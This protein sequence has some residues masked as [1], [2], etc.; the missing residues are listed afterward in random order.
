MRVHV[1]HVP[2]CPSREGA[3]ASQAAGRACPV[4]RDPFWLR[5]PWPG[6]CSP[7]VPT[8][9]SSSRQAGAS[10]LGLPE[11][12]GRDLWLWLFPPPPLLPVT[13][14][15]K[16]P[17]HT[18]AQKPA[19][20][21]HR[22]SAPRAE[23]NS[24][25]LQP[26][27]TQPATSAPPLSPAAGPPALNQRG[28]ASGPLPLLFPLQAPPRAA[29]GFPF[30]KSQVKCHLLRGLLRASS[31]YLFTFFHIPLLFIIYRIYYH[32]KRSLFPWR[33]SSPPPSP[34]RSQA[35]G[36]QAPRLLW[37]LLCP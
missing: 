1:Q 27:S 6:S 3:L 23:K 19:L 18:L 26:L 5:W 30:F 13:G 32:L 20:S 14:D 7:D 17:L 37:P 2:R 34:C 28:P 36:G 24:Q 35:P 15:H 10:G 4:P 9:R 31:G 12:R 11:L 25:S 8:A 22:L 16:R 29:Q 21:Q 33:V